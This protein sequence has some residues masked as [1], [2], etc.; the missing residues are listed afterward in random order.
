MP[1]AVTG[2]L[3]RARLTTLTI[4]DEIIKRPPTQVPATGTWRLIIRDSPR[5]RP[6]DDHMGA[7][8][9]TIGL[10]TLGAKKNDA[11]R[12]IDRLDAMVERPIGSPVKPK[13]TGLKVPE[14]EC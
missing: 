2:Q 14:A 9:T 6:A 1:A 7:D 11:L 10:E 4:K 3:D 13:E 12:L 8:R 5:P